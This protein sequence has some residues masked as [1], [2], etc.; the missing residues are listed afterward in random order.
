MQLK[1]SDQAASAS[2]FLTMSSHASG[3]RTL[4]AASSSSSSLPP[5]HRF[6]SNSEREVVIAASDLLAQQSAF[7]A[8][9]A[10][11]IPH[12]FDACTYTLG[13]IRQPVHLCLT[14]TPVPK[15]ITYDEHV[16]EQVK[17]KERAGVCAA[18]NIA[19]HGEHE[20][21]ELLSKRAFR[22]DCPTARM[23]EACTLLKLANRE[24]V[25]V[26]QRS[27]Y[28]G[29]YGGLKGKDQQKGGRGVKNTQNKYGQNFWNRFCR[30]GRP[31][32]PKMEKEAM[33][34]CLSC[35]VSR[36]HIHRHSPCCDSGLVPYSRS[37]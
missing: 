25:E 20:Q 32:N 19:C 1:E 4:N 14:C 30:C 12:R 33:I 15:D 28:A 18:C 3:S 8:D 2:P 17:M 16:E 34:Q 35:E 11:A 7:L 36:L 23:G 31:Y 27:S 22:C 24:G 21:V 13:Y 5:T 29:G 10:R 37:Q 6:I 26:A 9:A